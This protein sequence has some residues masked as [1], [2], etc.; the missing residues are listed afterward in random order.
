VRYVTKIDL[1]SLDS[2]CRRRMRICQCIKIAV[3]VIGNEFDVDVRL[4]NKQV[5]HFEAGM[6]IKA[7]L[8]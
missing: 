2:T 3:V 8:P 5:L 4:S 7:S 1:T 6:S